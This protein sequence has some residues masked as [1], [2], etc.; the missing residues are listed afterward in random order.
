MEKLP[1]KGNN[2][3]YKNAIDSKGR[4]ISLPMGYKY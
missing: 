3:E 1:K 2:M 4:K